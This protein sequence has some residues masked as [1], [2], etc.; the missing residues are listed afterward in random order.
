VL[1]R[2][3]SLRMLPSA[4]LRI[5]ASLLIRPATFHMVPRNGSVTSTSASTDPGRS[6]DTSSDSPDGASSLLKHEFSVASINFSSDV[7]EF[8]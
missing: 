1:L 8:C 6:V 3:A 4:S 5:L 2:S 7:G